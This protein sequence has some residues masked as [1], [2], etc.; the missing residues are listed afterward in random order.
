ADYYRY[1]VTTNALRAQFEINGPTSDLTLVARKGLPLPG[2]SGYD[3]I[4]ANPGTNDELITLFDFSSPIPLTPGEWF[5]SAVNLSSGPAVYPIMASECPV[6]GTG[7]VI[8]GSRAFSHNF[9]PT[10]TSL[11]C[12]R[13][14]AHGN[15]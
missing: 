2:L 11:S 10:C 7:I 15:T 4:S 12:L 8:T 3:L 5:L 1:V 13:Y 6:Y 14:F 9:R